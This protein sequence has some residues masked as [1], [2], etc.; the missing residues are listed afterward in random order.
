MLLSQHDLLDKPGPTLRSIEAFVG[1][2]HHTYSQDLL[3]GTQCS[4]RSGCD[5]QV[6]R[7]LGG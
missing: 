1:V 3:T 2:P 7:Q 5:Q 6:A 4:P